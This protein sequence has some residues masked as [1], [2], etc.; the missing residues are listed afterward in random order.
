M[1]KAWK[2]LLKIS[3]REKSNSVSSTNQKPNSIEKKS[4]QF[5]EESFSMNFHSQYSPRILLKKQKILVPTKAL[6]N[7]YN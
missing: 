2:I 7:S 3:K 5:S 6:K 4:N 1:I